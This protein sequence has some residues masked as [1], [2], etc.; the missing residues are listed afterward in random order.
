VF[1]WGLRECSLIGSKFILTPVY[2]SK[3]YPKTPSDSVP[4]TGTVEDNADK[5]I[6]EIFGG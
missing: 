6:A 3:K 4:S 2:I 5:R 1:F